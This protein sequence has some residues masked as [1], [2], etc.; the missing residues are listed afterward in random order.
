MREKGRRLAR[1]II[2]S[3]A[4]EFIDRVRLA[5]DGEGGPALKRFAITGLR[6][7]KGIVVNLT[8]NPG[9]GRGSGETKINR[10]TISSAPVRPGFRSIP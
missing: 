5:A 1:G 8:K 7:A 4:R 6:R 10:R 9:R 2:A 3:T